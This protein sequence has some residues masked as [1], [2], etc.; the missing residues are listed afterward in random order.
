[1]ADKDLK[2]ATPDTSFPPGAFL[3]GADSQSD[4][5]PKIYADATIE[6][7]ISKRQFTLR[8]IPPGTGYATN[9]I[10]VGGSSPAEAFAVFS[11]PD[12]SDTIMDYHGTA[13]KYQ[14]GGLTFKFAFMA[15]GSV[16]SG[17]VRWGAAIRRIADDADDVDASHS[18]DFN[19]VTVTTAS[20]NGELKYVA[21]VAFTDGADMDDLAEGERFVL[22]LRRNGDDGAD[23]MTA[24]AQVLVG[25][26]V[27]VET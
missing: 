5:D 1:M 19:E 8:P 11:F 6:K 10:R 15:G 3:F 9:D 18:Y 23:S 17:D 27:L 14:G 25:S 16:T 7:A 22:R 20:V 26:E 4:A 2:I 21:T 24:A 12:G 13:W